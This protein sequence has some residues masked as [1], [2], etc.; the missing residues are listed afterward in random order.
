MTATFYDAKLSDDY[1]EISLREETH[2]GLIE[3]EIQ[4]DYAEVM[5]L[6]AKNAKAMGEYLI[7]LASEIS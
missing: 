7:K 4:G 1:I 3:V 6:D 5:Y 2:S